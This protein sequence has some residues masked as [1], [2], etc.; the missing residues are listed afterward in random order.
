MAAARHRAVNGVNNHPAAR[1]ATLAVTAIEGAFAVSRAEQTRDTL[2][3]VRDEPRLLLAQ[4]L[5]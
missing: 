1:V 2:L 5:Q 4:A 3:A